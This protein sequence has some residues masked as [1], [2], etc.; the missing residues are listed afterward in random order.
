MAEKNIGDLLRLTGTFQ[1][2]NSVLTTPTT[3][4]FTIKEPDETI[5]IYVSGVNAELVTESDGVLHVDWPIVQEGVHNYEFEGVGLVDTAEEGT[6]RVR[7][8]A[9]A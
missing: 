6:F 3:V 1:N 5:T 4:T 2:I 7:R 8:R 9:V